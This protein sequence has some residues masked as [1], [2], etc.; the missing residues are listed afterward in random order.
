MS[1][2]WQLIYLGTVGALLATAGCTGEAPARPTTTAT[3]GTIAGQPASLASQTTVAAEQENE[4]NREQASAEQAPDAAM[5]ALLDGWGADNPE[6]LWDG[7]PASYQHDVNDLVQTAARRLHPEAWQWFLKI[8]RRGSAVLENHAVQQAPQSTD[9]GTDSDSGAAADVE[10]NADAKFTADACAMLAS[11]LAAIGESRPDTLEQLKTA[12]VGRLLRGKGRAL[13]GQFRKMVQGSLEDKVFAAGF[14]PA[15]DSSQIRV[16]LKNCSG[17]YATVELVYGDETASEDVDRDPKENPAIKLLKGL[18]EELVPDESRLKVGLV[19]VEGKWIPRW[20]ANRWMLTV[21]TLKSALL[22]AMPSESP[23]ENFG[24]PFHFLT[25]LETQ[26]ELWERLRDEK[27][28][29]IPVPL[30]YMLISPD[31]GPG[32]LVAELG[33]LL[34]EGFLEDDGYEEMSAPAI[35]PQDE[36]LCDFERTTHKALGGGGK[37]VVVLCGSPAAV[38]ETY[39]ALNHDVVAYVSE[40]LSSQEVQAADP[41][42]VA[43]WEKAE[44]GFADDAEL[45]KI[46]DTFSADFLIIF[47]FDE[48]E[49][50]EEGG[51]QWLRGYARGRLDVAEVA[52]TDDDPEKKTASV[53]YT[54]PFDSRYPA[55]L[56]ASREEES[57]EKF[58]RRF[59]QD[60]IDSL[61]RLLHDID[62]EP[63][64]PRA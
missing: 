8:M 10:M 59:L 23:R 50:R 46:A 31:F 29:T 14:L 33:A 41:G 13:L 51:E 28:E 61:T 64:P 17:D 5:R 30:W 37:S 27:P 32:E 22:E 53:I 44:G 45:A 38:R 3:T 34:V 48:L 26:L 11:L 6:A 12:D 36:R 35:P 55:H 16:V 40:L 57:K 58:Q 15:V 18:I 60:L 19:R 43:E 2:L 52:A 7:L 42:R 21:S 24:K 20:L 63:H 9:R 54:R 4:P 25:A 47:K 1:R 39:P 56:P 62:D 49:C